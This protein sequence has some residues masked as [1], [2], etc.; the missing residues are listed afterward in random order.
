MI[1]VKRIYEPSSPDDGTRFL[2]DRLWP[3]GL[4]KESLEIKAWLKNV[5]P[6]NALRQ[7]YSH[8]P[9]KVGVPALLCGL[10][11]QPETRQPILEARRVM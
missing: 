2:V 5:A 9:E 4:R 3:R 11:G 10:D 8:A 1:K 6:S 7:W